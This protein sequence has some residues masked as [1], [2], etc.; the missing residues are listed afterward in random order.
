MRND[1]VKRQALKLSYIE[2]NAYNNYQKLQKKYHSMTSADRVLFRNI[3]DQFQLTLVNLEA[4]ANNMTPLSRLDGSQSDLEVIN[5]TLRIP[6]EAMLA[7]EERQLFPRKFYDSVFSVLLVLTN[8]WPVNQF[9]DGMYS[10]V[11]TLDSLNNDS[12]VLTSTGLQLDI[13]NILPLLAMENPRDPLTQIPFSQRDLH[14]MKSQAKQ[15]INADITTVPTGLSPFMQD[16]INYGFSVG[17]N[18]LYLAVAATV[19]L[20]IA[21]LFYSPL[22]IL[23]N[24]CSMFSCLT[25]MPGLIITTGA[26]YL[27]GKVVERFFPDQPSSL[28]Q[29]IEAMSNGLVDN[30]IGADT[31]RIA[32]ELNISPRALNS[33]DEP[34]PSLSLQAENSNLD[35]IV[36]NDDILLPIMNE[37]NQPML[38]QA[39]R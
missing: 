19:L 23:A 37:E 29:S 18:I 15:R 17:V 7:T 6:L 20:T 28:L 4:L 3:F 11:I 30:S 5:K 24:Y 38:S 26:G 27:V 35:R 25:L 39:P 9:K 31:R 2:L 10:C 32:A 1:D 14:Y 16:S 21:S 34:M 36:R 8:Y 33:N 22:C 12:R 13:Q